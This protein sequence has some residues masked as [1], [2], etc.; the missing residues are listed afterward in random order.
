MLLQSSVSIVNPGN[1]PN[2]ILE[3]VT[4]EQRKYNER[5]DRKHYE[6]EGFRVGDIVYMRDPPKHTG[7]PVKTQRKYKESYVVVVAEVL[8]NDSNR[9]RNI[10]AEGVRNFSTTAHVS[11][12]KVYRNSVTDDD[13]GTDFKDAGATER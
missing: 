10:D 1:V 4:A 11:Q 13:D 7:E 3:R 6:H 5:Y 12:V 2:Q 9:V 8:G